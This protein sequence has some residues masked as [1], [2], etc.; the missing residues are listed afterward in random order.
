MKINAFTLVAD[1]PENIKQQILQEA[2]Q[3]FE[4]L[5]YPVAIQEELEN[6]ECSKMCDIECTVDVQKYYTEHVR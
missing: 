3:T 1:L 4:S 2:R 6:V 5:S